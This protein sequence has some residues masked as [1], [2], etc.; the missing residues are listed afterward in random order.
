MRRQVGVSVDDEQLSTRL[1]G[2]GDAPPPP[3][4]S[5]AAT[6]SA[7]SNIERAEADRLKR[8]HDVA[9]SRQG[10]TSGAPASSPHGRR[11][12]PSMLP[13]DAAGVKSSFSSS[14]TPTFKGWL[15]RR[16]TAVPSFLSDYDDMQLVDDASSL[17]SSSNSS[18]CSPS[19]SAGLL[20]HPKPPP[21][22]L[23][24]PPPSSSSYGAGIGGIGAALAR[25][26]S[27]R[28]NTP[29]QPPPL[30]STLD[31]DCGDNSVYTAPHISWTKKYCV[32]EEGAL[33]FYSSEE[34]AESEDA[35]VERSGFAEAYYASS[36]ATSSYRP[37]AAIH[38]ELVSLSL[39]NAFRVPCPV[40]RPHHA[41]R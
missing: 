39:S 3:L 31:P 34:L 36:A 40:S 7:G 41:S 1:S 2:A 22:Y 14:T 25:Q 16:V 13:A 12:L 35:R 15:L 21:N 27:V 18:P 8:L 33:F 10:N 29:V 24:P 4:L 6:F 17:S 9:V 28:K 5:A 32:L 19:L 20:I 30:L 23:L 26:L 37:A 38:S 11:S